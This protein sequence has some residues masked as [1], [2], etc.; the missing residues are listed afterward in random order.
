MESHAT[1]P[2]ELPMSFSIRRCHF[3]QTE[4]VTAFSYPVWEPHP[5][6]ARDGIPSYEFPKRKADISFART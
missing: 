6:E 1:C 2:N 3:L 5:A 4:I